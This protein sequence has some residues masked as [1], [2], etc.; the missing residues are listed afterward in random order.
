M[1]AHVSRPPPPFLK[2]VDSEYV[3]PLPDGSLGRSTM[4]LASLARNVR[5][6]FTLTVKS[7]VPAR[8][9]SYA[10][11]AEKVRNSFIGIPVALWDFPC[12]GMSPSS[13]HRATWESRGANCKKNTFR[14][15]VTRPDHEILGSCRVT[16]LLAD[17][18]V[19][20]N[21]AGSYRRASF[22]SR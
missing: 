5:N 21:P 16:A 2:S 22:S 17:A 11:T 19:S 7:L 3:T 20:R 10:E 12:V 1:S 4:W 15:R 18:L 6:F 8:W 9:R 13:D 14:T